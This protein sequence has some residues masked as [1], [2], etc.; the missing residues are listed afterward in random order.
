MGDRLPNIQNSIVNDMSPNEEPVLFQLSS[1]LYN[2]ACHAVFIE[3]QSAGA[4][5]IDL[6]FNRPIA[7]L[8]KIQTINGKGK[9]SRN[10]RYLALWSFGWMIILDLATEKRYRLRDRTMWDYR[11]AEFDDQ[12]LRIT[13]SPYN[14]PGEQIPLTPIPIEDIAEV[15]TAESGPWRAE[16]RVLLETDRL[17]MLLNLCHLLPHNR[18]MEEFET[19]R[20]W[21]LELG[22]RVAPDILQAAREP[23]HRPILELLVYALAD[24]SYAPAFPDF[25]NWLSHENGEIVFISAYQLDKMAKGRFEIEKMIKGGWVQHDQIRAVV[26]KIEAW[27]EAEGKDALPTHEAWLAE[28]ERKRP[29]TEREKWF[30]FVERNPAWVKQGDGIVQHPIEGYKMPRHK[31]I[32]TLGGTVQLASSAEPRFAAIEVDSADEAIL[33]V[34]IRED[35]VWIDVRNVVKQVSLNFEFEVIIQR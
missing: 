23:K 16:S 8:Q 24:L 21:M 29:L 13:L 25:I 2:F 14:R 32:H 6:R 27:W 7:G 17:H 18:F 15:L 5:R 33:S 4:E 19:M 22:P 35:G 30:N 28:R 1:E 26:P 9:L 34:N 12:H 31:G 20:D 10:G 3:E 11:D